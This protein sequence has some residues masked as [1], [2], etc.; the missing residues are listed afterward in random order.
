V[1][2]RLARTALEYLRLSDAVTG[3]IVR[4]GA[5]AP[6]IDQQG[7]VF[8]RGFAT[9]RATEQAVAQLLDSCGADAVELT[10]TD[11]PL[12][13]RRAQWRV[14]EQVTLDNSYAA[15]PAA[16]VNRPSLTLQL[17][18]EPRPVRAVTVSRRDHVV[19][20]CYHERPLGA[21]GVKTRGEP[22]G[23]T[24]V[25]VLIAVGPDRIDGGLWEAAP[26]AREYFQCV[27]RDG[28]LVLLFQAANG[29][30]LHGWWD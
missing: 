17:L 18:P 30:Y 9:A 5:A 13:E 10:V 20:V 27:T 14:R 2:L 24:A 23:G 21:S 1:W 3:I 8:D 6:L 29:W 12:L 16:S 28:R 7:D 4:V 15:S 22:H 19:P 25:D 26:Y 11:H